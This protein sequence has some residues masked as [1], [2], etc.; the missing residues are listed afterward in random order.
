MESK[1]VGELS[2]NP[3]QH[4]PVG[5]PPS[6]VGWGGMAAYDKSALLRTYIHAWRCVTL[7]ETGLFNGAGSGM[8]I[9][10]TNSVKRYIALDYQ[11]ENIEA[12]R[13]AGFEA[14]EGDSAYTLDVILNPGEYRYGKTLVVGQTQSPAAE[15]EAPCLFWLDAHAVY[16]WEETPNRCPVMGELRAILNWRHA[17][18]SVVLIDDLW[19]FGTVAGW[20]TLDEL[21]E[22]ADSG[23]WN[24]DE[25]EGSMRL[26]PC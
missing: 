16:D 21:R 14:Y 24:R 9:K 23:P 3:N 8:P 10:G 15:I 12:A 26:T 7:I 18:Q 17:K 13:S 25:I 22:L 5:E 2:L 4:Q 20:P 11:R 19:G 6:G 1:G